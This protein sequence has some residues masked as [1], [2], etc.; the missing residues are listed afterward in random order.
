MMTS[1]LTLLTIFLFTFNFQLTRA[2]D[3]DTVMISGC[4]TDQNAAAIAGAEVEAKLLKTGQK[5]TTTTNAEGAYRLIQL[6]PGTYVIHVSF[7]GFASQQV[8]NVATVAG[9][10][11]HFDVT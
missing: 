5:R 1:R 4:V 2:Q 3:L 6:E 10:S 7:P 11:L 8:A 9:Q